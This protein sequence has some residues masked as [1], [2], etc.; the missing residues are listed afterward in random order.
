MFNARDVNKQIL[1]ELAV[2]LFGYT[3]LSALD[4]LPVYVSSRKTVFIVI[5]E[6]K[7]KGTHSHDI[8]DMLLCQF[9]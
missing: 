9:L 1:F 5:R 4:A 3:M 2:R 7:T 6:I 8:D